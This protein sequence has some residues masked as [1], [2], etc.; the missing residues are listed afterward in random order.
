[1]K[2]AEKAF[3][4]NIYRYGKKKR[5]LSL[6]GHLAIL[7]LLL[8]LLWLSLALADDLFY[9]SRI[10]R[11]GLLG[12]NAAFVIWLINKFLLKPFR[13][14]LHL[15]KDSD[16]SMA[17]A[18]IA[19]FYPKAAD[20]FINIYQLIIRKENN[21]L[22]G[23]L[24]Q[25]AIETFLQKFGR[26]DYRRFLHL[27]NYLPSFR[28]ALPVLLGAVI[29][30]VFRF[31]EIAHSTL[32]LINPTNEYLSIPPY[33]FEV[34]PGNVKL[35]KGETL[36]IK[37]RYSGPALKACV[38]QSWR[39]EHKTARV[40][41][42]MRQ[43][44][45]FYIQ[46]LKEVRHNLIYRLKGAPFNNLALEG[47]I[48]S[49]PFKITVLTPPAVKTLDLTVTPPAYTRHPALR[50]Q[51]NVGDFSA[52]PG[53]RVQIKI[54]A[55]KPVRFA[56]FLFENGKA[57]PLTVSGGRINGRFTVNQPQKYQIVL[58]DTSGSHNQNPITYQIG[59][60]KDEA[61][62][63]EINKPGE[64]VESRL[65]ASLLLRLT[66]DDD[67]GLSKLFLHY[68]I[69]SQYTLI[70]QDTS[71]KKLPLALRLKA[72]LHKKLDYLWNFDK[73]PLSFGNELRYFASAVDNN[74][75]TGASV[76]KSRVYSV[77]FPSLEEVFGAANKQQDEE[78]DK[79]KEVRRRAKELKEALTKI[80]REMKRIKKVDW[81]KKQRLSKAVKRQQTLE[82]KVA[83]I[84]KNLNEILNKLENKQLISEEA[85]EKYGKLQQLLQQ[86]MTPELQK[87]LSK[88]QEAVDKADAEQVRRA[89]RE[90]RLQQAAFEKSIERAMELLKQ[91]RFEQK[92]D[93]LV[94]KVENL[95]KQQK[96]M[97]KQLKNKAA[98]FEQLKK[99]QAQQQS[100]L[101]RFDQDLQHFEKEEL[102]SKFPQTKTTLDSINRVL[103]Q[104]G[105]NEK[106][107]E[108]GQ[109]LQ[110][111]NQQQAG[112]IS[113]QLQQQFSDMKEALSRARQNML[114]QNKKQVM[115]QMAR[116][117]G[118]MLQLSFKQ[119]RL[120]RRTQNS[121][122]LSDHFANITRQQGE[123]LNDLNKVISQIIQL[124]KETFALDPQLNR[125]LSRARRN[126]QQALSALAER[127]KTTALNGQGKAMGALN[128][129]VM[130]MQQSMSGLAQS[131]S[132]T[133]FEAFLKQLQQMAGAQGQ[134]NNQS[135]NLFRAQGNR[136][137]LSTAQQQALKRLAARQAALQQAMQQLSEKMGRRNN[138]TGDLGQMAQQMDE[139]VKDLLKQKI[140]RQTIQRQRQILS[141]LLE[142]QKSLEQRK[143]S[144]KRQAV[145][146]KKY[147]ARNPGR[148]G[149]TVAANKKI[150]E[151]ALRRSLKSGYKKDYRRLIEAYFKQLLK[152]K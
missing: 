112:N 47:H 14:Y 43:G 81:E 44:E 66:A 72:T 116:A 139:V 143:F 83:E 41:A 36:K 110:S 8:I 115:Q 4:K 106:M 60:L 80:D 79:L 65:D 89:L 73:L 9:F 140:D 5:L 131:Q 63:V 99:E 61:P 49:R 108:L 54:T 136:G 145:L 125:S 87:T 37:V 26:K 42:I 58:Q 57:L 137:G 82:K 129:G 101:K 25:A 20:G 122:P 7:G 10:T 33:M 117:A 22:S 124:S 144:K 39:P 141:R 27:K 55:T 102:L 52:L 19:R 6:M 107:Q 34:H 94:Q 13:Y 142:A 123:I 35:L 40:S 97:G 28:W 21:G 95:A 46:N 85:L 98:N 16:L 91:V 92:M 90:F 128:R 86:V 50:L 74:S 17:A 135:L 64:D 77:R 152:E 119:E 15:K 71:W 148:L 151:Q 3:L 111:A 62:F 38:L 96:K 118:R 76:G 121:S 48:Y 67:Y 126:M 150:I 70:R 23:A 31:N 105:L 147:L 114:Q 1:M 104:A 138:V 88:L 133:G 53:S 113:Q 149:E 132:G 84:R 134:I 120:R 93:E 69:L 146:G 12:I 24:R 2:P 32:R 78:Q 130:Q 68:Q 103:K 75:V 11:W 109:R 100:D 29:I 56:S 59:L 18:E 30:L 127:R 51:R 45:S